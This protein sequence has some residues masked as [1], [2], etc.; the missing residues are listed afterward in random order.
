[1]GTGTNAC[2]MEKIERCT[3]LEGVVDR[4]DGA[5]DEVRDQEGE[6]NKEEKK[7]EEDKNDVHCVCLFVIV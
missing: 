4:N 6:K 7:E 3:K 2:Y 5:P 1:M